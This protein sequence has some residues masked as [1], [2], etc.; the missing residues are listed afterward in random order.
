M[1]TQAIRIIPLLILIANLNACQSN[2]FYSG[3]L[4]SWIGRD[5]SKLQEL[6]GDPNESFKSP[7][8]NVIYVWEQSTTYTLH[9]QNHPTYS[10]IGNQSFRGPINLARDEHTFWCRTQFE[11]NSQE[12]IIAWEYEGNDCRPTE[13]DT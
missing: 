6:W 11:V 2:K 12:S 7:N 13:N 5:I 3:E 10:A 9:A 8:G 4:D 1:K